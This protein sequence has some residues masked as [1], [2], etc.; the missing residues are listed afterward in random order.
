MTEDE[1]RVLGRAFAE[2]F[3]DALAGRRVAPEAN[4]APTAAE[5]KWMTVS[6]YARSRG[7]ARS[8]VTQWVAAGLPTVP[9]GSGQ[10]VEVRAA[11]EWIKAGGAAR[12]V[13]LDG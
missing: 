11:D 7:F 8:T 2:G 10:R 13:R 9:G 3:L 5:P 12:A 4:A 6:S 1:A